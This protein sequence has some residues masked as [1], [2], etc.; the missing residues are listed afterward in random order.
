MTAKKSDGK[1]CYKL[2]RMKKRKNF[3]T[4]TFFSRSF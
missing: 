4:F 3:R 1:K 2:E